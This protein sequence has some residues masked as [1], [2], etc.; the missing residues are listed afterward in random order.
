MS[1][2]LVFFRDEYET[3]AVRSKIS[4]KLTSATRKLAY[5]TV[6]TVLRS[7]V[8]HVCFERIRLSNLSAPKNE[9]VW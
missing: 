9:R 8:S 6:S 4:S 2:Y 7:M 3:I 1:Q 5:F